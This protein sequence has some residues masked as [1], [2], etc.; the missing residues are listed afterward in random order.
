MRLRL[1]LAAMIVAAALNAAPSDR[2]II[3]ATLILEAGG[4]YATGS[5]E[6]VHEV[7]VNRSIRRRTTGV[8]VC[9]QPKQFSCWNNISI[10]RGVEI[11]MSHPRWARA[12]EIVDSPLTSYTHG[13]D[14]YHAERVSPYWAKSMHRTTK[15]GRHIFYRS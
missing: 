13:A 15:I 10:E 8:R 11:A 9:L 12:L 3:A 6:A 14:H 4:E 5:M 2:E 7:I 1:T